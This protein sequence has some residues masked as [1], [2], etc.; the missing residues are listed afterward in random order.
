MRTKSFTKTKIPNIALR[1]MERSTH[2]SSRKLH[3]MTSECTMLGQMGVTPKES[4]R[5][6]VPHENVI[7]SLS[8]YFSFE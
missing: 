5:W 2:S 1:R 3:W 7:I 6:K 4:W 8:L